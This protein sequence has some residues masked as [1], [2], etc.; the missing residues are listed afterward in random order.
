MARLTFIFCS[1][2]C[3]LGTSSWATAPNIA[4]SELS[5]SMPSVQQ[6]KRKTEKRRVD[7]KRKMID[8]LKGSKDL[9][10]LPD[11]A[12]NDEARGGIFI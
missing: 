9:T 12:R 1:V 5:P 4:E 8:S 11:T 3:V 2:A 10:Q 7:D 6:A